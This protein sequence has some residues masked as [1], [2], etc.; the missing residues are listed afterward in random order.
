MQS[1]YIFQTLYI[2]GVNLTYELLATETHPDFAN[3]ACDYTLT[4]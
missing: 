2:G 4:F 1:Q 3:I